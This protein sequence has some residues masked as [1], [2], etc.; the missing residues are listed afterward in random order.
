MIN[1]WNSV[2][3]SFMEKFAEKYT[4]PGAEFDSSERDPP[5]KCH[6]GTR[7]S[8]VDRTQNFF[9]KHK[10]E[11]RLLWLVGPAGVGKS[12]IMQTLAENASA[13]TSNVLLGASLFF[14]INGRDRTSKA[15][16]TLAY[17][18]AVAYP[19]YCKFI[20]TEILKEP[21]LPTKSMSAQF[22]R[23]FT[24]PFANRRIYKES[25]PLLILIDGI[26]ECSGEDKQCEMVSLISHFSLLSSELIWVI[27]SRPE[28]HL[29]A[30][31]SEHTIAQS[32]VLEEV[33]IDS[34][35]AREDAERYLRAD[36]D[37]IRRTYPALA[38]FTQWPREGD[39][40]KLAYTSGGLFAYA[41]TA[42]RFIDDMAFPNPVSQL[43]QVLE[44]I[45][46]TSSR[47]REGDPHPMAN[48]Y[49]LYARVI[50][51]IHKNVL[52]DT[53]KILLFLRSQTDTSL[54]RTCNWL[55]ITQDV[56]HS[57]LHHLHSVLNI[58]PA[59]ST[60]DQYL[61]FHHKSFSEYISDPK[62]SRLFTDTEAETEM[63]NS[64]CA[65]RILKEAMGMPLP[66]A[67]TL[68]THSRI[69]L[70]WEGGD[71]EDKLD[72]YSSA[73]YHLTNSLL[74]SSELS[75]SRLP[76]HTL[77][78][79]DIQACLEHQWN[80]PLT[81]LRQ[82]LTD[83]TKQSELEQNAVLEDIPL[84]QLNAE[85]FDKDME[86]DVLYQSRRARDSV[87]SPFEQWC[88]QSIPHDGE[89]PSERNGCEEWR[90]S[91]S[92]SVCHECM[93]RVLREFQ[94]GK[95]HSPDQLIKVFIDVRQFAWAIY[96]FIYREDES[97]CWTYIIPY[98][99]PP[100]AHP[101]K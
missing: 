61:S 64:Q 35:E 96:E 39:F 70:Y 7:L 42:V 77:K 15:I 86:I 46:H 33:Q 25:K 81:D 43:K 68:S 75:R 1:D 100:T 4:I 80:T 47:L 56:M 3:D 17:Q 2:P 92:S 40:L 23:L 18:I 98:H 12:A 88:K 9:R 55:G 38:H 99:S 51:H 31:F 27:A 69:S 58:P 83:K 62:R 73:I 24:E 20:R 74:S 6:P 59:N 48:L 14:S 13:P 11:K 8:I 29:S 34:D 87:F 78:A 82:L 76:I 65:L 45:D 90:I 72:L 36:L 52:A 97:V 49:A 50:F 66:M 67:P 37:R 22:N 5:P 44:I 89:G 32:C 95:T 84:R 54:R 10:D 53:K 79:I 41:S 71:S 57:A 63:L 91:L 19:P 28:P 60:G 30:K 21:T 101:I 93:E 26:D 94:Y 85:S 16:L